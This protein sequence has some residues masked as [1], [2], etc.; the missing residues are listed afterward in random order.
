MLVH[1][2]TSIW[3]S[4]DFALCQAFKPIQVGHSQ[5]SRDLVSGKKKRWMWAVFRILEN[6]Q[7]PDHNNMKVNK[8]NY[9]NQYQFYD[10]E[11]IAQ[12]YRGKIIDI[13][14]EEL[15]ELFTMMQQ[16]SFWRWADTIL[17]KCHIFNYNIQFNIL[18]CVNHSHYFNL[19]IVQQH[20]CGI[21]NFLALGYFVL[22]L[23]Q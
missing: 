8:G 4:G 14:S 20:L 12:K 9:L 16:H 10:F 1:Q 11:V 5:V 22:F 7:P 18:F 3:Q 2:N 21:S 19:T 15:C 17:Y 6:P 23:K 13:I